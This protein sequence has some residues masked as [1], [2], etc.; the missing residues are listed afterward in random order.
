MSR[1]AHRDPDAARLISILGDQWR[2]PQAPATGRIWL[3]VNEAARQLSLGRSTV[4]AL[5]ASGEIPA[6]RIGRAVRVPVDDLRQWAKR[7]QHETE[8]R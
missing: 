8:G 2:A 6:V 7:R 3:T 4:Y 1:V 5:C